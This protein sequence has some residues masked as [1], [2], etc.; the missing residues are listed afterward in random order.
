MSESVIGLEPK[1][2]IYPNSILAKI[3]I[4]IG[5]VGNAYRGIM[6]EVEKVAKG[7]K[8]F[9]AIYVEGL[10]GSGKTLVL[11]KA[12]YDIMSG[13]AK[14]AFKTVLPIYFFLG[15]M[16]F[17]PLQS[18]KRYVEDLRTYISGQRVSIGSRIIGE[19]EDWKSSLQLLEELLKIISEIEEKYRKEEERE[20]EGFFE[21]LREVNNRGSYPLV[22]FDEFERV[23]YTGEG[24]R[25]EGSIRAFTSFISKYLELTRGH[26]YSG[27]FVVAI[28]RP[29]IELVSNAIKESR[30][31]T[32]V[33][34]QLAIPLSKPGDFPMVR[35]HIVYDLEFKL[36]WSGVHLES[37]AKRYG[38]ILHS[39]LLNLI[40][41][42]LPTPRAIIQI[43][44]KIR[45]HLDK[46]P[47]VV[48]F[49]EFY[50]IIEGRINE[51]I[52]R[53]KREFIEGRPIIA[54][55]ATWHERFVEL[56]RNGYLALRSKDYVEVAKILGI[57][58]SDL[59]K[60][61]EKVGQ[62]LHKLSVLGFYE[63]LGAGEYRL[64]PYIFAY[65]LE[66]ENL[67][68][69]SRANIDELVSKI[70]NTV[71]ELREEHRKYRERKKETEAEKKS[72]GD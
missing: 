69:G 53:L 38:F 28:T 57:D 59:R 65:A 20:I 16:D 4:N 62:L 6:M 15:E 36:T 46:A 22:I 37:L 63:K 34:D 11:R 71:K 27:A 31:L 35:P 61:R 8:N 54:P 18:L 67:P 45:I 19:R 47:S 58:I 26:S 72:I 12:V 5:P 70:K 68:D 49:K 24:L 66:I 56:L 40:S 10:Y 17:K 51:L 25:S 41:A 64:N 30:P 48:S 55:R 29:V 52:E 32:R 3:D 50:S 33:F 43:D 2:E 42:V 21:A 13:P 1:A 9:S 7:V 14:D 23:L 60:C 44:R 39:D